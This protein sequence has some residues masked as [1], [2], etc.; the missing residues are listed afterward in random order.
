METKIESMNDIRGAVAILT[1]KVYEMCNAK[2]VEEVN[3]AMSEA[4]DLLIA[5]YKF[6]YERCGGKNI[7]KKD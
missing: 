2:T 5:T 4:K 1:S 3:T 7:L 6:N